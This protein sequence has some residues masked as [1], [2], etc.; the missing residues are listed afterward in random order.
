MTRLELA[1][2][3]CLVALAVALGLWQGAAARAQPA[4]A[5]TPVPAASPAAIPVPEIAMRA[6]EIAATLRRFRAR[7]APT[8]VE[9]RV[10]AELAEVRQRAEELQ[11]ETGQA[12]AAP[13]VPSV[14]EHLL[15]RWQQL[16][17]QLGDWSAVLRARATELQELVDQLAQLRAA[18]MATRDAAV[19]SGAPP[20]LVAR[21]EEV[22][23]A[24]QATRGEVDA[25][26]SRVLV[27]QDEVS[28][29]AGRR[30]E[31][32]ESLTRSL[33]LA[34]RGLLV[35][36]SPP[37]WSHERGMHTWPGLAARA[38]A[39]LRENARRLA[40]YAEREAGRLVAQLAVFLGVLVLLRRARTRVPTAAEA[41][42][43]L[44]EVRA[45]LD[46]PASSACVLAVV[47][48]PWL[49]PAAPIAL[50]RLA[51]LVALVPMIRILR[52]L[53]EP[54]VASLVY[55]I[56]AVIALGHLFDLAADPHLRQ[57]FAFLR[58]ACIVL[59]GAWLLAGPLAPGAQEAP[60]PRLELV[61]RSLRLVVLVAGGTALVV[62][63]GYTRIGELVARVVLV[64]SYALFGLYTAARVTEG[65]LA[66]LLR[67]RRASG[68]SMVRGHRSLL[69]A[70]GRTLIRWTAVALWTLGML[71]FL[72]LL[73]PTRNAVAA[74]LGARAAIGS[75]SVSVGDLLAF[76]V[77]VWSSFLAAALVRFVLEEEILPR[78]ALRRG[79]AYAVSS[80]AGYATLLVGFL[81]ALAALRIDLTHFT[82]LVSAFGVGI[83]FGLQNVVNNFVS[84]LILLFERP[85]QVGD[86]VQI[87]E[88]GG[89]IR[90]IGFR[91]STIR[92]W[93]GAEV[94]V[95]NAN[96]VSDR[97]T[98][99]TL[100]DR[101]RRIDLSVGVAYGS[102]PAR[103]L[104]ILRD[105]ALRH[106]R[107]LA[108]PAPAALFVGFGQSA[109]D[110]QLRA[111]TDRF[112]EWVAI[113]SDL[114]L[115]IHD[116]LADA[117]IVI[118]FPQQ[119]VHLAPVAPIDVR[120]VSGPA[121]VREASSAGATEREPGAEQQP[122]SAAP[123]AGGTG[124]QAGGTGTQAGGT[125]A[126][127]G[128]T[129]T[130]AGSAGPRRSS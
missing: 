107:V 96:L 93:E 2:R 119:D 95:P 82:I 121:A 116:A 4:P 122:S 5:G 94:I 37:I 104:E 128:S 51:A 102:K 54:G 125:G 88:L 28:R 109:L 35:A 18:W 90:R 67:T 33:S 123:P 1:A 78:L 60:A 111:W 71:R 26:R 105:V 12:L 13:V 25:Q 120:L 77:V 36:D 97:V 24:V 91:S 66:S 39:R 22:L 101:M 55:A 114:A 29:S 48:T 15:D 68:L 31:A 9:T 61:R 41:G 100:S 118:P 45:V 27:L 52:R 117:G 8:T 57:A 64:G 56:A 80:L 110:F 30:D 10:A 44:A 50:T 11:L 106:P 124:T 38:P 76:G 16:G 20:A 75:F 79:L 70:R 89:E 130:Q 98:N 3:P 113:R 86:S 85:L 69:E 46:L 84:G 81:L 58:L 87:A 19:A 40:E 65:L 63:L 17:P 34:P 115:G 127:A 53:I 126:Q 108:D 49:H 7:A 42:E 21:V 23:A 74:V 99:W 73:E 6:E 129:G 62:A 112:E 59:A 14:L 83:G 92:T 47:A 103:V 32:V 72:H 43:D